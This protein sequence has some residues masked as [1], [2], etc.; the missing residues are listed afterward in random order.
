MAMLNTKQ[1]EQIMHFLS[2]YPSD[3]VEAGI[4]A[5]RTGEL[6]GMEGRV[7]DVPLA[8]KYGKLTEEARNEKR[9]G[10]FY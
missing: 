10:W 3:I 7:T 9:G 1:I 5:W 6:P 8:Q 4:E 2:A